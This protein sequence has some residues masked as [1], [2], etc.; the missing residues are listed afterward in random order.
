MPVRTT[1]LRYCGALSGIL[2]SLLLQGCNDSNRVCEPGTD[3]NGVIEEVCYEIGDFGK[4]TLAQETPAPPNETC[5]QGG[6]RIDTGFDDNDNG[7]LDANEVDISAYICNGATGATGTNA[8][9]AMF[10]EEPGAE[11]IDGGSRIDYGNDA[12][13]DGTLDPEE[14]VALATFVTAPMALM[15]STAPMAPMAWTGSVSWGR[16]VPPV[17]RAPLAT[18]ATTAPR[19]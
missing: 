12:D 13:A 14:I 19:E 17:R 16:R 10:P 2:G 6:K 8:I 15:V 11:C 18:T 3:E 9:T 4:N 1:T 5:P 7:V